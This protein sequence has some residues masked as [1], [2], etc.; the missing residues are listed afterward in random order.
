MLINQCMADKTVERESFLASLLQCEDGD[1]SCPLPPRQLT[2]PDTFND[3][4]LDVLYGLLKKR[5]VA[6]RCAGDR[7]QSA[8][9]N[10]RN[11][12]WWPQIMKIRC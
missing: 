9:Q 6:Q 3:H 1:Q 5:L 11:V 8:W 2:Y 7:P 4:P 12:E 10:R